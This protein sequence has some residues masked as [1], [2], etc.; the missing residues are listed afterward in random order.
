M[1]FLFFFLFYLLYFC[2]YKNKGEILMQI[3]QEIEFKSL[4]EE[5]KFKELMMYF[6]MIA[7]KKESYVQTNYYFDDEN[8][9]L[10]ERGITLR[11]RCKK[12]QWELTA[13]LPSDKKA[14]FSES[15]EYNEAL[16]EEEAKQLVEYGI[17]PT[18]PFIQ[19]LIVLTS[20]S[21]EQTFVHLDSL[22]TERH[23]F[24]F[25]TDMIS[26]DKSTYNGI[27]DYEVE[28]ETKTIP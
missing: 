1:S 27:T 20:I 6:S 13:K 24:D 9:S 16:S 4:I 28:W 22:Q 15:T 2:Q 23:D 17:K 8:S 18:Y 25:Y 14:L 19:K 5:K 3:E 10:N 11:L 12:D 21:F 26:L 7:T